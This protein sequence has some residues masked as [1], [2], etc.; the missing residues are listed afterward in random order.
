MPAV[1]V[2]EDVALLKG[3]EESAYYDGVELRARDA[4]QF[5]NRVER[6]LFL[7]VGAVRGHGVEC[8]GDRYY[9]GDER[10]RAV[11]QAVRIAGAV[12][13]FLVVPDFARHVAQ[14]LDRMKDRGADH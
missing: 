4:L 11:L 1:A 6:V 9:S 14:F 2:R 7:A 10:D 12:I 3:E 5:L 13:A 8:V